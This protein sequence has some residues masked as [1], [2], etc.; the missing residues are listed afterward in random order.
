MDDGL[1]DLKRLRSQLPEDRPAATEQSAPLDATV[2]ATTSPTVDPPVE[3]EE[4][5]HSEEA[6]VTAAAILER[7]G[8]AVPAADTDEEKPAAAEFIHDRRSPRATQAAGSPADVEIEKVPA[9]VASPSD[10]KDG[11]REEKDGIREEDNDSIQ[12]YMSRLIAR[13]RGEVRKSS[14]AVPRPAPPSP[15][16]PSSVSGEASQTKAP[17][18]PQPMRPVANETPQIEQRPKKRKPRLPAPELTSDLPAMRELAKVAA[19]HALNQHARNELRRT[20]FAKIAVIATGI[21]AGTFLLIRSQPQEPGFYGGLL[22]LGIAVIWTLRFA[23]ASAKQYV[24]K[25]Q[26]KA[27]MEQVVERRQD[28]H[29]DIDTTSQ[30]N[31]SGEPPQNH[32]TDEQPQAAPDSTNEPTGERDKDE[33]GENAPLPDPAAETPESIDGRD[34]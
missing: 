29:R 7:L 13:S 21:A 26:T 25:A 24:S 17:G 12:E 10:E 23:A 16:T 33:P 4:K 27:L 6:P 5:G 2:A 32:P 18:T 3:S 15:K 11:I 9:D 1:E 30:A 20:F 28:D 34:F 19:Q 31:V 22:S 8:T 14:I